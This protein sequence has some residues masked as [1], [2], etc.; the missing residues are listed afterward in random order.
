MDTKGGRAGRGRLE[1][2]QALYAAADYFLEQWYIGGVG[3][4]LGGVIGTTA[5]TI[6]RVAH[7]LLGTV[8]AARAD[9]LGTAAAA[10]LH[11][12]D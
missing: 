1:H 10:Y 3:A 4:E 6:Y 5:G 9:L 12:A 7:R 11:T 8:G 2:T